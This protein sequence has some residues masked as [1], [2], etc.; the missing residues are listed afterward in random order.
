M[1]LLSSSAM[2]IRISIVTYTAIARQFRYSST[3]IG[4]ELHQEEFVSQLAYTIIDG[5]H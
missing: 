1:R 3:T 5:S 2:H 4:R